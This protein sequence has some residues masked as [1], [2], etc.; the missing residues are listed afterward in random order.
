MVV[1]QTSVVG[2][3]HLV[4]TLKHMG[5]NIVKIFAPEHGFRGDAD[6]GEHIKHSVDPKTNFHIV[7]LYGENKNQLRLN[8]QI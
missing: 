5:I 4:D 7:S 6:A 3:S 2:H 8:F 1:N